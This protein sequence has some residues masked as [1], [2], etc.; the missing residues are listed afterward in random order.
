MDITRVIYPEGSYIVNTDSIE[1]MVD[2]TSKVGKPMVMDDDEED[3]LEMF[4]SFL[5]KT[6]PNRF[7][8]IRDNED[9]EFLKIYEL[10]V[11]KRIKTKK[12]KKRISKK[13]ARKVT[14]AKPFALKK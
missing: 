7:L 13:V 3:A 5:L 1:D 12:V 9:S 14:R 2:F 6:Y 4:L 11:E 10:Y 8:F